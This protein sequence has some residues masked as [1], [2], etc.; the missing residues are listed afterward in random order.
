M[1]ETPDPSKQHNPQAKVA[2]APISLGPLR[3]IG[4]LFGFGLL[5]SRIMGYALGTFICGL[6]AGLSIDAFVRTRHL[7]ADWL[8]WSGIGLMILGNVI[9]NLS[10]NSLKKSTRRKLAA[11]ATRREESECV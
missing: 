8:A 3:R 2:S 1:S 5:D 11:D 10:H 6:G 9:G 7:P 4:A